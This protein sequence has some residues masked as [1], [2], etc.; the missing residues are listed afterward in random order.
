VDDVILPGRLDLLPGTVGLYAL[1]WLLAA[2]SAG[3]GT[4]LRASLGEQAAIRLRRRLL[5]HAEAPALPFAQREHGGRTAALFLNDAP[6][7]AGLLS[8]TLFAA[9]G[10]LV[11]TALGSALMVS[12]SWRLA[13]VAGAAPLL[14]AG[15]AALATRPLRPAAG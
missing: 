8:G 4:L 1:L 6:I 11:V 3:A 2:A 10:T 5:A 14:V 15:A 9:L 7:V 12:L 13:L